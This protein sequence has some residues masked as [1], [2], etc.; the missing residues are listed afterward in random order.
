MPIFIVEHFSADGRRIG[1]RSEVEAELL[2]HAAAKIAEQR[3][4][5]GRKPGSPFYV[6]TQKDRPTTRAEFYAS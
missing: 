2:I 5:S 1:H 4:S 3:I 6:V